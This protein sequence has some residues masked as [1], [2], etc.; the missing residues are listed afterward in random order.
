VSTNVASIVGIVIGSLVAAG[1]VISI[2]VCLIC[3][4]ACKKGNRGTLV[5]PANTNPSGVAV[6]E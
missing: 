4:S 3:S 2:I 6:G 1:I 5:M